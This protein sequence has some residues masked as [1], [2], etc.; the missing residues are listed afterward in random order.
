MFPDVSIQLCVILMIRYSMKYISHK[1]ARSFMADL[2][3]VYRAATLGEAEDHLVA[4]GK[5]RGQVCSATAARRGRRLRAFG[6]T[7]A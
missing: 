3:L 4:A 7:K 6:G 2:K 1:V 5:R